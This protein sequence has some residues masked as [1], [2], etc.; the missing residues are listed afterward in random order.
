MNPSQRL[1]LAQNITSGKVKIEDLSEAEQ[2][3]AFGSVFVRVDH[4]QKGEA[5]G[6]P[7]RGNQWTEGAS[8]EDSSASQAKFDQKN[9][10]GRDSHDSNTTYPDT[11]AGEKA[12]QG[13]FLPDGSKNPEYGKP[14]TA[15]EQALGMTEAEFDYLDSKGMMKPWGPSEE[16]KKFLADQRKIKG[17]DPK[18]PKRAI[19]PNKPWLEF[20]QAEKD[21]F[22]LDNPPNMTSHEIKNIR[23]PRKLPKSKLSLKEKM[24]LIASQQGSD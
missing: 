14:L 19:G 17:Y 16:G 22:R 6:H 5:K 20:T 3:E 18:N 21:Q 8:N 9:I 15:Q 1:E 11:S 12:E 4:L 23:K 10:G 24:A 7:F 13:V 2:I